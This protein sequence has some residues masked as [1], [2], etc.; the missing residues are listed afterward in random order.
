M[1]DYAHLEALL[2]VEREGSFEGAVRALGV[3]SSA[4]SQRIR[5]LEERIGAIVINR[6]SPIKPTVFG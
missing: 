3:T 6:Q 1:F 4:V 2:A 5:L